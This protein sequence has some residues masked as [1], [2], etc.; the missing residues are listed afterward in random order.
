MVVKLLSEFLNSAYQFI[1]SIKVPGFN[2]SF[3]DIMLGSCG[4]LLSISL[5]K[6][7]FGLGNS[8]VSS[9]GRSIRGGNNNNI[10]ISK[11]RKGDEN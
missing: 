6:L 7:I 3:M 4:A 1:D 10:K 2:I 9:L 11:N 8:S 5:L